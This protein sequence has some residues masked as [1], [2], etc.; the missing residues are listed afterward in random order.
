MLLLA[1][2]LLT[3]CGQG[4][5]DDGGRGTFESSA[6]CAEVSSRDDEVLVAHADLDGDGVRDPISYLPP[7]SDCAPSLS[8]T[9]GG[10]ERASTLDDDLPIGAKGA[11]AISVPGRVGEIAV[12]RH[13]QETR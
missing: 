8:A 7:T 6:A 12:L 1:G 11:F 3:G 13:T 4:H 5:V 10:V 9:V 2:S